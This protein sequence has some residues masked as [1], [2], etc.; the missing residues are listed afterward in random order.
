MFYA[1]ISTS[2]GLLV[3]E[4]KRIYFNIL[5]TRDHW[6]KRHDKLKIFLYKLCLW[7]GF[8][9]TCEVYGEFARFISTNSI[10]ESTGKTQQQT[11]NGLKVKV[12]QGCVPDLKVKG[13]RAM[14]E[15][16]LTALGE[17]KTLNAGQRYT[18]GP[19]SKKRC[20]PVNK[21]QGQIH[22]EY[23]RKAR[24]IDAKYNNVPYNSHVETPASDV[25]IT[26]VPIVAE[27]VT[28]GGDE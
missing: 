19:K 6:R 7:A 8:E 14:K 9:T 1:S 16:A 23:I 5:I 13:D 27:E 10:V 2:G 25:T 17:V 18:N 11:W 20:V 15:S 24:E 12:R 22:T 4:K 28:D 21:R 26:G 3:P